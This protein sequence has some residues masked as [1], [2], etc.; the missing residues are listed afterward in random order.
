MTG[1]KSDRIAGYLLPHAEEG[2]V[3][4]ILLT[5]SDITSPTSLK[6]A[7]SAKVA[8]KYVKG[9]LNQALTVASHEGTAPEVLAK[10]AKDTRVSVR[11]ALISNPSTPYDTMV[12][13]AHWAHARSDDFMAA[14][15]LR[16]N[17]KDSID[18]MEASVSFPRYSYPF[19]MIAE[20]V[21][22][23]SSAEEIIRAFKIN[24]SAFRIQLGAAVYAHQNP[25]ISLTDLIASQSDLFGAAPDKRDIFVGT[26]AEKA[27]HCTLELAQLLSEATTDNRLLRSAEFIFLADG[28]AEKLM[29]APSATVRLIATRSGVRGAL[30]DNAIKEASPAM[31]CA[32]VRDIGAGFTKHQEVA[33]VA[34]LVRFATSEYNPS[35]GAALAEV[36]S[37]T[38]HRLPS[39]VILGAMRTLGGS[40]IE[41]W[42]SGSFKSNPPRAGE[43]NAILEDRGNA[44]VSPVFR[45]QSPAQATVDDAKNILIRNIDA[46]MRQSWAKEYAIAVGEHLIPAIPRSRHTAAWITRRFHAAF[47][48]HEGCWE[49]ALTLANNWTGDIEELVAS[50]LLIN[51]VEEPEIVEPSRPEQLNFADQL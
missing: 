32:L 26:I 29:T 49:T 39:K 11:Q 4:D 30:L 44:F 28:A 22:T 2:D 9:K 7:P 50:V 5:R 19:E 10:S 20:K 16:L 15:I 36:L 25:P 24:S 12:T 13:L 6:A 35:L 34:Q 33:M 46:A 18:V 23:E 27:Q 41:Y 51:E 48:A 45:Y 31:V 38:T 8:G 21:V 42:L 17:A 14:S 3:V 1:L 40:S 43:I 47:G 37:V